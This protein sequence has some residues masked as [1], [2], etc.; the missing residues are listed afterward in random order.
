[1]LHKLTPNL[2]VDDMDHTIAFYKDVLGFTLVGN[3]PDNAPFDWAM[4]TSGVAEIM[5]QSLESVGGEYP[6]FNG[7][8]VGGSFLLYI[9]VD[10]VDALYAKVKGRAEVAVELNDT[11][12]GMREFAIEDIDGYLLVF[13]QQVS[14]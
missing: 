2:I 8:K 4:M 13:A 14:Q 9:E 3:A 6:A 12:Y 7:M 5:F 11:F 10:D 1:M